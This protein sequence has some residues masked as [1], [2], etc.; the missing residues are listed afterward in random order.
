M[1]SWMCPVFVSIAERSA[2][3]QD[4]DELRHDDDNVMMGGMGHDEDGRL[5]TGAPMMMT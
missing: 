3:V 4:A 2:R 1:A 5:A